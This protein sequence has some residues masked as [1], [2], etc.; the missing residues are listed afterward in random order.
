[1]GV[2]RGIQEVVSD[3]DVDVTYNDITNRMWLELLYV[4]LKADFVQL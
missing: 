2:G 3:E 1:M 4:I